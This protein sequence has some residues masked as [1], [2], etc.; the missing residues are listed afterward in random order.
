MLRSFL[1]YFNSVN[2]PVPSL[3]VWIQAP[4]LQCPG[5]YVQPQSLHSLCS[6]TGSIK[7][8]NHHLGLTE[9]SLEAQLCCWRRAFHIWQCE[10]CVWDLF[11]RRVLHSFVSAPRSPWSFLH[12]VAGKVTVS[13]MEASELVG[14]S[15]SDMLCPWPPV[16]EGK[17]FHTC[18]NVAFVLCCRTAQFRLFV[19][20][21]YWRGQ[22]MCRG[23]AS[24]LRIK[25]GVAC[26][27]LIWKRNFGKCQDETFQPRKMIHY[28]WKSLPIFFSQ[29]TW[30]AWPTL[31]KNHCH[32]N[33]PDFFCCW[34]FCWKIY[35]PKSFPA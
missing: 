30:T 31:M 20:A 29:T 5:Q 2:A 25:F 12:T 15:H 23:W 24:H 3:S 28:F 13:D 1:S 21:A 10:I 34:C 27:R 35:L 7:C 17:K 16:R 26:W 32:P 14:Q 4:I 33:P 11:H 18:R 6:Q 8:L 9:R 22:W 19:Q